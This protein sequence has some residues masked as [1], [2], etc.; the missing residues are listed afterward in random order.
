MPYAAAKQRSLYRRVLQAIEKS[1]E[2]GNDTV[3]NRFILFGSR[4]NEIELLILHF[5]IRSAATVYHHFHLGT[6]GIKIDRCSHHDDICRKHLFNHLSHIV[7]LRTG[8]LIPAAYAAPRARMYILVAQE[9][10]LYLV[11]TL[12]GSAHKF[13]AKRVRIAATTGTG[14]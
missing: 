14:R 13:I 11:S 9:N 7:F 12:N 6:H 1:H 3:H 4:G 10:F 2:I 8:L 5:G